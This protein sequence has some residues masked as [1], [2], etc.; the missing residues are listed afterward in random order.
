LQ[1]LIED[2]ILPEQLMWSPISRN[3]LQSGHKFVFDAGLLMEGTNGMILSL[4]ANAT[5]YGSA[6]LLQNVYVQYDVLRLEVK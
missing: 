2:Q 3:M 6:V 4:P 5:D 1:C